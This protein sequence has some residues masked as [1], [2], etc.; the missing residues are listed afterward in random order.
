MTGKDFTTNVPGNF[1]RL[2]KCWRSD[3]ALL[4]V[5]EDFQLKLLNTKYEHDELSNSLDPELYERQKSEIDY[6]ELTHFD[7]KEILDYIARKVKQLKST[8]EDNVILGNH[9]PQLRRLEAYYRHR[10]NKNAITTFESAEQYLKLLLGITLNIPKNPPPEI[11]LLKKLYSKIK[12][13]HRNSFV[14]LITLKILAKQYNEKNI[15][16]KLIR[17][18][19]LVPNDLNDKT[20][21]FLNFISIREEIFKE[22]SVKTHFDRELEKLRQNKKNFFSVTKGCIS[23]S[24]IHSFKGWE[25]QN[26]FVIIDKD[27]TKNKSEDGFNELVYTAIT[28][29]RSNLFIINLGNE[30][31]SSMVPQFLESLKML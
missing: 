1:R 22:K 4:K 13:H 23:M 19:K 6:I 12:E 9:I 28:R 11:V 30:R 31:L 14:E 17:I 20:D 21:D 7:A 8:L 2:D 10:S 29:A 26:V 5:F 16:S 15:T 18:K 3:P 24:T 25:A 27:F